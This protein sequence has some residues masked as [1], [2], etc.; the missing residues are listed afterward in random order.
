MR[1][2]PTELVKVTV[3]LVLAVV[4]TRLGKKIDEWRSWGMLIVLIAPLALMVMANNLSS[5]LI[6]VGIGFVMMF[7]AC[8]KKWIFI[9]SMALGAAV[10]IFAPMIAMG[11]EK[12]GIL[13]S[14][15]LSRILVWKNPEAYPRDGGYQVL[16]GLYAIGLR[17]PSGQ[18][19]G[20]EHPEA[21]LP[22]GAPER[23]DLCHHLRGA[24]PVRGHIGDPDLF[25]HDLP[26]SC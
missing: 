10:F 2:Q 7:I 5:G 21:Q 8:K 14:Y 9:L 15:Q 16:Q 24:G 20:T 12:A 1:F 6:I 22:S 19:A 23:Y 26:V 3:I 13:E 18:G 17:R 25:I 11:L 4:I